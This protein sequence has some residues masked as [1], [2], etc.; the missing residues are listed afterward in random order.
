MLERNIHLTVSPNIASFPSSIGTEHCFWGECQVMQLAD[1]Q[2]SS[3]V[4]KCLAVYLNIRSTCDG[5]SC[6]HS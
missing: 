2:E 4:E 1:I 5:L 3:C 6:S